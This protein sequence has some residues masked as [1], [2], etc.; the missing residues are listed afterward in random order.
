MPTATISHQ[1]P[2][3]P[4]LFDADPVDN[5]LLSCHLLGKVTA[6]QLYRLHAGEISRHREMQSILRQ[7]S[8]GDERL[9]YRINPTDIENPIRSLPLVYL[10][11]WASRRRIETVFGVPFR[12]PPEPPSRDWR[13]LEHD[14]TLPD[15]LISFELTA[16]KHG[17]PIRLPDPLR[18]R[19]DTALPEHHDQRWSSYPHA[20]APS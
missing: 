4:A 16:R 13:F 15:D 14:A 20:K 8:T 7:L 6:A 2:P 3:K 18:R 5:V 10:D 11:T 19:G 12:R 17:T 9:L 1:T